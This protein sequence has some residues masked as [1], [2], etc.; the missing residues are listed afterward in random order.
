MYEWTD[1]I[2]GASWGG[3]YLCGGMR[4]R[5]LH[6]LIIIMDEGWVIRRQDILMV[7]DSIV[8]EGY[9]ITGLIWLAGI[10]T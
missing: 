6:D 9:V 4:L 2:T 3:G 7:L 1:G 10:I 8:D 5:T